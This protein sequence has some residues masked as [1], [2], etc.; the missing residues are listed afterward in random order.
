MQ[1]EEEDLASRNSSNFF[2]PGTD[3]KH[4]MTFNAES[5]H[6]STI[7]PLTSKSSSKYRYLKP[8]RRNDLYPTGVTR[9]MKKE[10]VLKSLMEN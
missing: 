2:F 9:E 7:T 8:T 10:K 5:M 6:M 1:S 4:S 3:S